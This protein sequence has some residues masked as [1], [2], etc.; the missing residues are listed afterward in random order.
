M[1]T[2]ALSP[3]GTDLASRR[4]ASILRAEIIS[5]LN[6]HHK[7]A[8][9]L[10]NVQSISDSYADE[11]FGILVKQLGLEGFASTVV[12]RNASTHVLRRIAGA[13]KGRVELDEL[14]NKLPSLVAAKNTS[15][16]LLH[17]QASL[18]PV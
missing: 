10:S 3:V 11:L 5:T 15:N 1:D 17:R 14:E 9:D 7:V 8:I 16:N 4:S 6:N 18:T 2:I 12:I 13:I